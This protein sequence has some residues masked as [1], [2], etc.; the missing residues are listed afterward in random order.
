[1]DKE[2]LLSF[3][4]QFLNDSDFYQFRS[5]HQSQPITALHTLYTQIKGKYAGTTKF[6]KACIQNTLRNLIYPQVLIFVAKDHEKAAV[7]EVSPTLCYI[8]TS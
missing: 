7:E 4:M 2:I 6:K 5:L 8:K 3:A 1:M